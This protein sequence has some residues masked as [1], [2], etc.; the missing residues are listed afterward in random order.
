MI[1]DLRGWLEARLGPLAGFEAAFPRLA[2]DIG[3]PAGGKIVEMV[4][5]KGAA[6]EVRM[7][8]SEMRYRAKAGN[9]GMDGS[10]WAGNET[11]TTG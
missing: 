7:A 2:V 3:V 5:W 4:M 10:T 6:R 8:F 1:T 9:D 11:A